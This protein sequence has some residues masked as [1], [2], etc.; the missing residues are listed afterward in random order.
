MPLPTYDKLLR[1]ILLL[2][3]KGPIARRTAAEA[4]IEEFQL[5]P[6]EAARILPSGRSTF[7]RNRTGWAMTFLTKGGLIEKVGVKQYR[8]T[9]KGDAFLKQHPTE[10]RLADLEKI[11]GWEEAWEAGR[12][13]RRAAEAADAA[14]PATDATATPHEIIARELAALQADLRSRLLQTIVE[15]SP[16][17]FERLVLDVLMAMGY[18]GSRE[19]ASEHLG[20]SGD[21][22][23][24]GRINQ[25][26]AAAE[27]RKRPR[28]V[29]RHGD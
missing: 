10:I 9:A 13:K 4:M 17:F 23:I 8:A 7:I 6:E 16:A 19:D 1:P 25:R 11:E 26:I 14:K 21:E 3:A 29:H 28:P 20:R 5:T 27:W 22:G 15:Q 18:G 12:A 24:D 2:A